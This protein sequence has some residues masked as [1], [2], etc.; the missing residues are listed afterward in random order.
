MTT[1][2]WARATC[3]S[4]GSPSASAGRTWRSPTGSTG[5]PRRGP[6]SWSS[7]T[8][9]WDEWS[10]RPPAATSLPATWWWGS[11]ADRT[12]SRA[13]RAAP[14]RGTCAA[15][16]ATP[17]AAS[18]ASTATPR[19]LHGAPAPASHATPGGQPRLR[20]TPKRRGWRGSRARRCRRRGQDERLRRAAVPLPPEE[21][22][23]VAVEDA[24]G[25][26]ADDRLVALEDGPARPGRRHPHGQPARHGRDDH[27]HPARPRRLATGPGTIVAVAGSTPAT[28]PT[29]GAYR[30]VR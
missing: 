2:R 10:R 4:R 27:E 16:G 12:P 15:T 1:D 20:S 13:G 24:A 9:R 6:G 14:G 23:H 21:G 30:R 8:S 17:S 11:S 25:H 19:S 29:A 5:P 28:P 3:S 22:A 26:Q 7:A 18:R